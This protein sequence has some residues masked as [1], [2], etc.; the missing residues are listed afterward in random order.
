[1]VFAALAI[2][3][4][5]GLLL[6]AWSVYQVGRMQG[7]S[8]GTSMSTEQ[9]QQYWGRGPFAYPVYRAYDWFWPMGCGWLVFGAMFLF[10]MLR[11]FLGWPYR[12]WRRWPGRWGPP[13]W[14][15]PDSMSPERPGQG[16]RS[17]TDNV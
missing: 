8:E 17:K 11:W 10:C 4:V 14:W 5:A 6:G 13:P 16:E 3:V 7:I 2:L 9:S 1:M 15:P 12:H